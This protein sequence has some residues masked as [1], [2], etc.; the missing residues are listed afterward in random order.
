MLASSDIE[1]K[2]GVLISLSVIVSPPPSF[3]AFRESWP[4]LKKIG[5]QESECYLKI[6]IDVSDMIQGI[7][8]DGQTRNVDRLFF[9]T[10]NNSV[11]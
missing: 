11:H 6:L 7:R 4:L 1:E 9:K 10:K 2:K 5:N 8:T 3:P